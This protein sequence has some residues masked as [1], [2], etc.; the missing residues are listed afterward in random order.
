LLSRDKAKRLFNAKLARG[1]RSRDSVINRHAWE[2]FH[3]SQRATGPI[4]V[5]KKRLFQNFD[6]YPEPDDL[7]VLGL[8]PTTLD[9]IALRA[10]LAPDWAVS[11]PRVGYTPAWVKPT[12]DLV[13]E[14]RSPVDFLQYYGPSG[15]E[16]LN[17]LIIA[18]SGLLHGDIRKP[19]R[20]YWKARRDLATRKPPY[21]K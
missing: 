8:G 12:K 11:E 10:G 2:K 9:A 19:I 7:K 20:E 13:G 4:D 18:Q 3:Q 5:F 1:A 17:D 6:R 15:G 16:T 14:K 21:L